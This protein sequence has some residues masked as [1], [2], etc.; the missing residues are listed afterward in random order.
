VT[1]AAKQDMV[2]AVPESSPYKTVQD[3]IR[4]AKES[5]KP[6]TYPSAGSGSGSHLSGAM[7]VQMAGIPAL[8]VPYK[9]AAAAMN[10]LIAG[11]HAF[12]FTSVATSQAPMDGKRIR[13][14][15][16]SGTSRVAI[17][18]NVP[19]LRESGLK[20]YVVTSWYGLVVP[21][22]TPPAVIEKLNAHLVQI[23]KNPKLA[24]MFLEDGMELAPTSAQEF[25]NYMKTEITLWAKVIKDAG[26]EA[27]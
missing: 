22:K 13:V 14:L 8:H 9:G 23:L 6:F 5:P 2:L 17:L 15:G 24:E 20:D 27:K 7:F 26:L 4:A 3:L 19:T 18:P 21:A 12:S 16:T 10:D 1:L 11:R 25:N